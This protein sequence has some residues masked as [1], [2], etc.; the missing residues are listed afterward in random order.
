[1]HQGREWSAETRWPLQGRSG[2]MGSFGGQ[3]QHVCVLSQPGAE[4]KADELGKEMGARS[5][6][7]M[8]LFPRS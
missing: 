3:L 1:M 8:A 4:G 7:L 2:P 5:I 6:L